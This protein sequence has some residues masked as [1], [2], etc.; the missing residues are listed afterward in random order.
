VNEHD[1]TRIP[2]I[3]TISFQLKF[4]L[5]FVF[6][7]FSPVEEH[8]KRGKTGSDFLEFVR[9]GGIQSE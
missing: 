2:G 5:M 9:P 7:F 1:N 3:P 6:H 4:A 8:R